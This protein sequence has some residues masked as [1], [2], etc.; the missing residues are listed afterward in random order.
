MTLMGLSETGRSAGAA[1]ASCIIWRP[2]G[3]RHGGLDQPDLMKLGFDDV[4]IDENLVLAS[5]A[6]ATAL[7]NRL[8][9]MRDLAITADCLGGASALLEMTVEHLITR[10]QYGRPLALFQAL[11]HRCADLQTQTMAAE[12][13]ILDV[14]DRYGDELDSEN[15]AIKI[16]ESKYLAS[17]IFARVVEES[18][19]LHG[20]IGMAEEH[21]CHLFLK[22]AM[23]NQHLGR[24]AETC[25]LAIAEVF[26]AGSVA[27][28]S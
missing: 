18:L 17:D 19:Q 4:A 8:V 15:A 22:R 16:M 25:E 26:F 5:G 9:S 1:A 12:A 2:G 7:I 10:V 11:K 28:N 24:P 27:V 14:L 6:E 20:G 23:L 3:T 21:P 13:L